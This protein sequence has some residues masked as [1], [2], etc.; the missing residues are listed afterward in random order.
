MLSRSL[1]NC[2]HLPDAVAELRAGAHRHPT[3]ARMADWMAL[4]V[5]VGDFAKILES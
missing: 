5:Q 1:A 3:L 2:G 4:T